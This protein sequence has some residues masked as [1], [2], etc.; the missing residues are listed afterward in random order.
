MLQFS[1]QGI[2]FTHSTHH[3][4]AFNKIEFYIEVSLHLSNCILNPQPTKKNLKRIPKSQPKK[5]HKTIMI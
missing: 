1:T 3:T 5:K 2:K 4:C